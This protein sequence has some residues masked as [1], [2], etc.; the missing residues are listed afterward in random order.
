M[1]RKEFIKQVG[2]AA[3]AAA[4]GLG[5]PQEA[6]ANE[7]ASANTSAVVGKTA[8]VYFSWSGNTRFAAEAIAKAE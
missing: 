5:C 6:E 3:G 2:A 8:V 4:L 7:T 1:K